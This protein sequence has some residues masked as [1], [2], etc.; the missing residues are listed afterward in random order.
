MDGEYKKK[1]GDGIIAVIGALF[2]LA[3][4]KLRGK[5]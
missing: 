3:C 1:R 5:K 2:F 4:Y